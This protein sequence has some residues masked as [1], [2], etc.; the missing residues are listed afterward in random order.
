MG[1]VHIYRAEIDINLDSLSIFTVTLVFEYCISFKV[2][3]YTLIIYH[4]VGMFGWLLFGKWLNQKF[5][6]SDTGDSPNLPDFPP[7]KHSC[8]MV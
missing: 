6:G 3:Y 5:L 2:F 1:D 7:S 4:M 8:Y